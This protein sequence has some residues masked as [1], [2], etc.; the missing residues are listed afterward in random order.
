MNNI[1]DTREGNCSSLGLAKYTIK[2]ILFNQ[3]NLEIL[4]EIL[5]VF[6]QWR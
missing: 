3:R 2:K 5:D 6:R 4:V 1:Y